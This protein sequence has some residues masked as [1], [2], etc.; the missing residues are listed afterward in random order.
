MT[1]IFMDGAEKPSHRV[2]LEEAGVRHFGFSF[3]RARSRGFPKTKPYRLEEYFAEDARILV[4]SGWSQVEKAEWTDEEVEAYAAEY[5]EFLANNM[6]RIAL[7]TELHVKQMGMDWIKANRLSYG[8]E[9]GQVIIPV[10]DPKDGQ[11][12]LNQ[13]ARDYDN[14]A[15]PNTAV[16]DPLLPSRI[17]SLV[18][19]YQT[20][21]H[22]LNTAK[23][24]LLKA[25]K[26][27][28]ATTLSWTSPQ[29]RGET[30]VWDGQRIVRYPKKMK[31]QARPR[32]KG[33]VEKAGLDFNKILEDDPTEN[34]RLAIW[35]YKQLEQSM[36]GDT[37]SNYED[38]TATSQISGNA[39]SD[40]AKKDDLMRNEIVPR[41]PSEKR[42]LPVF[43]VEYKQIVE[44]ENGRDV[45]KEVPIIRSKDESL[46][47]CN[48]CILADK[49][50]AFTPDSTCAFGLPVE[51]RTKEQLKS[52]L[53]AVIEM[54]GQ[55][56]AFARFAEEL[57]GGYPD[58]NL[59]VEIDRLFKMV[60]KMKELESNN[61]FIKMTVERQTSG[62][63]LS[64]LFGD[65][66]E[67]LKELPQPV[68]SDDVIQGIVERN[69]G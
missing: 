43:G 21:F 30:I 4:D 24:D 68:Q 37:P 32:T 56:V 55:R 48:T 40:V 46:R 20:D 26:F 8:E 58:P 35:S 67:V 7:A 23:P 69:D 5:D 66:A 22:A 36:T 18:R 6:D 61:E 64:A 10:W 33:A 14:V 53:N 65:R 63:V 12:M 27:A 49:C 60:G 16:V 52:L 2:L 25:A 11:L 47:Q 39:S 51:V 59:G 50:P 57:N 38:E 34:T 54:Q 28:T 13:L 41:D 62:G 3:W 29:M 42:A 15:I 1:I 9:F 31:D 44:T 19:Q 45:V 17:N